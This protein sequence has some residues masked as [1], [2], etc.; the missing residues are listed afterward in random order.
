MNSSVPSQH[1][2]Q[3]CQLQHVHYTEQQPGKFF[4]LSQDFF[5]SFTLPTSH[6]IFI[7]SPTPRP[8]QFCLIFSSIFIT[9]FVTQLFNILSR[10]SY[11]KTAV[12]SNT[13]LAGSMVV[14]ISSSRCGSRGSIRRNSQ[15]IT[16]YSHSF[17]TSLASIFGSALSTKACLTILGLLK[18][19]LAMG[20]NFCILH[21]RQPQPHLTRTTTH[22][23]EM[24]FCCLVT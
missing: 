18:F 14:K 23:R 3:P 10:Y 6:V 12:I 17:T 13:L 1:H 24:H 19:S 20:S 9:N 11:I 8:L 16:Q 15:H 5:S 22:A 4:T 7:V 2:N 21:L